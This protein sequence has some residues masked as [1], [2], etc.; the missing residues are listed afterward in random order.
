MKLVNDNLYA[1]PGRQVDFFDHF[2]ELDVTNRWTDT[3][4]DSGA[5][6]S[7]LVAGVSA[8]ALTAGT[9]AN[10]EICLSSK[11][12]WD[13]VA[14][15]PLLWEARL[16]YAEAA[17]SAAAML[18]G[19]FSAPTSADRLVD[20]TG[21]LASSFSGIYFYK[22]TGSTLWNVGS[23]V[24][25]TRYGAHATTIATTGSSYASFRIEARPISSTEAELVYLIDT[26]GG[27]NFQVCRDNSS[28]LP[29]K[30]ILTYTSFAPASCAFYL[31]NI[32]GTT[33][34]ILNVDSVRVSQYM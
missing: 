10:N 30:D 14:N 33:E 18:V 16:Q 19:L 6:P 1:N 29:I 25:S 15:R 17:T 23:S 32:A 4:G 26:E 20:T 8:V 3:S 31:K 2:T 21:A 7:L 24:G 11:Q 9:T 22:P 28:K 34:E 27:T 12:F 13:I 5:A